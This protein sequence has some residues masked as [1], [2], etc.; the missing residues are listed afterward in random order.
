MRFL[1]LEDKKADLSN[2]NNELVVDA[3]DGSGISNYDRL[4]NEFGIEPI[5]KIYNKL[6]IEKRM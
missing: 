4:M 6:P 5:E 3:L 1:F 2:N